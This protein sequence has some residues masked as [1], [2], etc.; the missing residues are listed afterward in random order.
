ML[1]SV[2]C[3]DPNTVSTTYWLYELGNLL[4]FC[5][6]QCCQYEMGIIIIQLIG[7]RVSNEVLWNNTFY[8]TEQSQHI[9][10]TIYIFGAVTIMYYDML[11]G[12]CHHF[13]LRDEEN[14]A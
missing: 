4:I 7:K 14:E 13:H 12:R 6:F 1:K 3:Q 11:Q 9:L 8:L 10:I 2:E 5:V